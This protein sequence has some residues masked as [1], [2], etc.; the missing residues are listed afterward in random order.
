MGTSKSQKVQS[1]QFLG[2]PYCT[3]PVWIDLGEE[4]PILLAWMMTG[5]GSY[6]RSSGD[7]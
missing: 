3:N 1:A 4:I 7:Q 6:L 2:V 5:S